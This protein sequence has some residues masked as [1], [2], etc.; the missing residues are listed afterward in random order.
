VG[1][2]AEPPGLLLPAFIEKLQDRLWLFSDR[3]RI[4]MMINRNLFPR[5]VG[6]ALIAIFILSACNTAATVAPA[7]VQAASPVPVL[8]AASATDVPTATEIPTA[9]VADTPTAVVTATPTIKPVA[10]VIPTVNAYCRSGPG[11]NYNPITTLTSGIAYDVIGRNDL[12]T[13]WLVQ[14]WGG[15]VTCW[16]GAPGTSLVGPVDQAPVVMAAPVLPSPS[17]F[18]YAYTCNPG[19]STNTFNVTLNW[20][21][22]AGATGYHLFR[23]GASLATL[24]ATTSYTD[25]DAPMNVTLEYRLEAINAVGATAPVYV[26]VPACD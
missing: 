17:M 16:T 18:M 2:A 14:L 1:Q 6:I 19:T 12:N 22:V 25:Y 11:S 20:E 5:L 23:N 4:W 21:S 9:T 10:Q 15:A 7:P 24:G 13:W 26:Q 8:P 3:E